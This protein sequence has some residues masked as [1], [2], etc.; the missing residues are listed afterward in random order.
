MGRLKAR[1][2][3]LWAGERNSSYFHK[4][5]ESRKNFKMVFEIHAEDQV[6]HDFEDI[7]SEATCHFKEIYSAED[8]NYSNSVLLDLVPKIVKTKQNDKLIKKISME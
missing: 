7:K 1:C 6:F 2:L 8:N 3:W 5:V 4:Q